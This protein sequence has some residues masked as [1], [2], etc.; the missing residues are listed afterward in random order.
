[1][2]ALLL[3]G[4]SLVAAPSSANAHPTAQAEA[5]TVPTTAPPPPSAGTALQ[6]MHVPNRTGAFTDLAGLIS[7]K[8]AATIGDALRDAQARAGAAIN[9]LTIRSLTDW[10]A[11]NFGPRKFA[12]ATLGAWNIGYVIRHDGA[13]LLIVTNPPTVTAATGIGYKHAYD[14]AVQRVLTSTLE[15]AMKRREYTRGIKDSVAAIAR[16]LSI[17]VPEIVP[18]T[19][20]TI[21]AASK[22]YD[23]PGWAYGGGVGVAIAGL[24]LALMR[25]RRRPL[26][27]P[28]CGNFLT[29]SKTPITDDVTVEGGEPVERFVSTTGLRL[30][31][32]DV[33]GH[34]V[35]TA[36]T[37]PRKKRTC[38]ECSAPTLGTALDSVRGAT[39]E[40]PGLV[41][42]RRVCSSCD[43]RQERTLSL[44]RLIQGGRVGAR[45]VLPPK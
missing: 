18:T 6:P 1:M 37:L 35:A 2:G 17:P 34:Y 43:F 4:V 20:V 40:D 16:I 12:D 25:H 5:P 10:N 36:P 9:V 39:S 38:P 11:A 45:H 8:N 15:P 32:C 28:Q 19:D 21:T 27:C 42:V 14:D 3:I 33:C 22:K 41:F 7:P 26:P 31:S 30:L 44:P 24:G 23:V 13:L 29:A